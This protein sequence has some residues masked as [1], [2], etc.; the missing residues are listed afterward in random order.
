VVRPSLANFT[1]KHEITRILARDVIFKSIVESAQEPVL[2]SESQSIVM[3]SLA[4]S[5]LRSFIS[6]YLNLCCFSRQ[7]GMQDTLNE[8]ACKITQ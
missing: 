3:C 2:A 5:H 4:T 8:L 6:P 1:T 7:I